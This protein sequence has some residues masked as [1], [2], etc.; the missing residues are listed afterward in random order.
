MLA[1]ARKTIKTVKVL[2]R[3][4]SNAGFANIFH[5]KNALLVKTRYSLY[6][7]C[8]STDLQGHSR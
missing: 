4:A 2:G 5:S 7:S 1:L 3:H 6:R 8:C